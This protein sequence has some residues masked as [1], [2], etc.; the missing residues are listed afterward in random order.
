MFFELVCETKNILKIGKSSEELNR[1]Q[2]GGSTVLLTPS[3]IRRSL[4]VRPKLLWKV[5]EFLLSL[6]SAYHKV[7]TTGWALWLGE[8]RALEFA[9]APLLAC[10]TRRL[11]GRLA[12]G[13]ASGL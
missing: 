5:C 12:P 9:T 11:L 7:R 6:I 8:L 13:R 10:R 4:L 2:M 3:K 1:T